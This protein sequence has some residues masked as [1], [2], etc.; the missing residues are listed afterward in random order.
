MPQNFSMKK[1]SLLLTLCVSFSGFA[2]KTVTPEL[3][4]TLPKVGDPA[5]SPDGKWVAYFVDI[6]DLTENKGNKDIYITK[7]EGGISKVLAGGKGGQFNQKWLSNDVLAYLTAETGNAQVW[8]INVQTNEKKQLT[9][10]KD[11]VG[12]YEFA[13]NG[14]VLVY[15][16][17]VKTAK[18]VH[19]VYPDLP[20][21]DA[22]IIDDLFYRHWD[23]WD[24]FN[25]THLYI[26]EKDASGMWTKGRDILGKDP[27]DVE[28]FS[29]S[30]DGKQIA[31]T[32]KKLN[33][34]A[35]AESTNT[36]I[37]LYDIALGQTLNCTEANL[38]YDR[39]PTF[40]PDGKK[41]AYTSMKTAGFESDKATLMVYD[42]ASKDKTD[43]T[44][45]SEESASNLVWNEAGD[46]I[47]YISGTEA[48][49][50]IYL[51][52]AVSGET[53]QL[54]KGQ[55]DYKSLAFNKQDCYG[56]RVS[57][58]ESGE[59]F[60]VLG[61]GKEV[62]ITFETVTAWGKIPKAKV[63]KRMVK[64]SDGK[65]MLVWMIFP[66][67]FD[68]AKKYPTLLYCQGGPQSAVSQFFSTRWNFQLMA[69]KGYIVVAPNRRGL[70]TFGKAWNDDISGDW[71]GQPMRDYLAAIDYACKEPYVNK[72]KLGAVGASYGGYSV[73]Q[74]AGTHQKRFKAF[75]SHCGLFNLESW[76]GTTE[77]MFFANYDI[78][79]PY[80][81]S[82]QPTSYEKFSPHKFV[83]NWDTPILV[84]HGEKD[85]RV[86][87]GEG[88]QAFQAAQLQ[89]IPS[90]FL[91]FP[92]EGHWVMKPQ[93]AVL[94]NRV[95][96]DWL[97]KYLK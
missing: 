90:R 53:K 20:K 45:N 28:D 29:V 49:Y 50:Q 46:R 69:S 24:D 72:D 79:G 12:D 9:S 14:K 91:Y 7:T 93:N 54:T 95:F 63:E 43:L 47:Y 85:F 16:A 97:D 5:V 35:F 30:S 32:S 62:Q 88:M 89:N 13:A 61:D 84:I 94:W 75:I 82:P 86:P 60:R 51:A 37:Y 87:I 65:E 27:F 22:R 33:G 83:K 8:Q 18:D 1:L 52:D 76:Y 34:K 19:D 73:Y 11:G 38:G 36:D 39:N 26:G 44:A 70:P 3:L 56:L 77:E 2:Q 21:V 10:I 42:I 40:S 96:F 48:T 4:A 66:P 25:S 41:F 81:K 23:S 74:L 31:Y 17:D 68:P 6:I 64:T 59:I 58:T 15:T 71:G 55:H 57:M 92:D 78:K 67:D 80:W